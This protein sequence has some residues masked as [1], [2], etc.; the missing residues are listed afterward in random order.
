M[1]M[2]A[3]LE[4]GNLATAEIHQVSERAVHVRIEAG[5]RWDAAGLRELS[6]L[7]GGIAATLAS[8]ERG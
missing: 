5:D 4:A 8:G 2:Q 3:K 6:A 1:M 7:L